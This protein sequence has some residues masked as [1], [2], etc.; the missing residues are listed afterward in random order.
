MTI[1][2]LKNG[3]IGLVTLMAL[4][5]P[6]VLAAQKMETKTWPNGQPKSEESLDKK[7]FKTGLCTYW[8]EN[9]QMRLRETYEKGRR[10]GPSE[11]WF[12][13][14]TPDFKRTF[15][16]QQRGNGSL[17][18]EAIAVKDGLWEEFY[19][20][21]Q[22][23]KQERFSMGI[24]Q[25]EVR[26]WH[27]NGELDE[28]KSMADKFENGPYEKHYEDGQLQ[29]RGQYVN[30]EKQGDWEWHHPN[31]Q[32]AYREI[33]QS[34]KH[35]DGPWRSQHPNGADSLTG[36][37]ANGRKEGIWTATHTNGKMKSKTLFKFGMPSGDFVEFYANGNKSREGAFGESTADVKRGREEGA[38]KEWWENG[39]LMRT[40]S[41]DNG[42]MKG[43]CT[44]W[45]AN[46]QKRFE[47]IFVVG[48]FLNS[49]KDEM[50]D[51]MTREWH[52]N[53]QLMSEG[54]Y[55][56]G[57]RDGLWKEWYPSGALHTEAIYDKAK[58]SGAVTEYY[59]NAKI[60]SKGAYEV[61]G[62]FKKRTGH[63]TT[64]YES[65]EKESEGEYIDNDKA[66]R[67]QEWYANGNQREDGFF[68][69][70]AYDGKYKDY[71]ENG[72]L[73][74][75]GEFKSKGKLKL[76]GNHGFWIPLPT[77]GFTMKRE[78]VMHGMWK[79]YDDRGTL[80]RQEA[81]FNGSKR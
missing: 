6:L 79:Y 54:A 13:D 74:S 4:T 41:Y 1:R 23:Q 3:K 57:L 20:N 11:G 63:W 10:S 46:G 22:K 42:Q 50:M 48:A 52:E 5:L 36:S 76:H 47:T 73:R 33:F 56:K 61:K 64:F 37:Y 45:Y 67:W 32:L 26:T 44:E 16:V 28:V 77:V 7:G 31:G 27:A 35:V 75:E 17:G 66:G 39:Q 58:L 51:G 69:K 24:L 70:G 29:T 62:R 19:E 53:G 59:E 34:D 21:G 78:S 55:M 49:P 38:W 9:A 43:P 15:V 68:E 80:M 71:F 2:G 72:Q 8:Y 40:V 60:R 18:I 25:G 65:G 12:E 14:G 81:W 30:G